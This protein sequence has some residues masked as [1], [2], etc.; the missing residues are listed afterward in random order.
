MATFKT[1][2]LPFEE[3]ASLENLTQAG[4]NS[5]VMMVVDG[6]GTKQFFRLNTSA[7]EENQTILCNTQDGMCLK[8]IDGKWV[9][10]PC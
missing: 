3:D 5:V 6:A 9:W 4:P 7:I 10:V 8:L 1:P 2:S